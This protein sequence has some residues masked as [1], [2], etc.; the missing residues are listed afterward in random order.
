[1]RAGWGGIIPY[2]LPCGRTVD[3]ACQGVDNFVK[4]F[5][6]FSFF[7][8]LVFKIDIEFRF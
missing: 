1:M 8:A 2:G 4:N 7:N 6:F 5:G 3:W